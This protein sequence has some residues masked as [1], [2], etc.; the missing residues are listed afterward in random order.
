MKWCEKFAN[1][2]IMNVLYHCTVFNYKRCDKLVN[3]KIIKLNIIEYNF[4][5][6]LVS[7]EFLYLKAYQPLFV[8]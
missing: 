4:T 3:R 2:K 8:I 6:P 7:L 1:R 5:V